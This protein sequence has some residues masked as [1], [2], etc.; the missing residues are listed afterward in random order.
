MIDMSSVTGFVP[1]FVGLG[2]PAAFVIVAVVG[3]L[4]RTP[5]A[6]GRKSLRSREPGP[7]DSPSKFLVFMA[8]SLV[9]GVALSGLTLLV[10]LGVW[11]ATGSEHAVF[12]SEVSRLYDIRVTSGFD[13]DNRAVGVDGEGLTVLFRYDEESGTLLFPE[14]PNAP[15]E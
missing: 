9:L 2:I 7:F 4:R 5:S 10:E 13:A 11:D 12:R 8:N 6:Q 3:F 14:W 15:A 1:V